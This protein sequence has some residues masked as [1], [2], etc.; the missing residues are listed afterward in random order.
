MADIVRGSGAIIGH[1]LSVLGTPCVTTCRI[2]LLQMNQL[3][4]VCG[5]PAAGFHFGAFT[6][7]GCKVSIF[8]PPFC[9]G[10]SSVSFIHRRRNRKKKGEKKEGGRGRREEGTSRAIITRFSR[11][12]TLARLKLRKSRRIAPR[13][14]NERYRRGQR[15]VFCES[16]FSYVAF[17]VTPRCRDTPPLLKIRLAGNLPLSERSPHA[18]RNSSGTA[19]L[20]Q[21]LMTARERS[22]MPTS[23]FTFRSSQAPDN[24]VSSFS[25][26]E[27]AKLYR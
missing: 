25:A 1:I 22:P 3:C 21:A 20:F 12:A 27:T 17:Y 4:R 10:Y 9:H 6:C 26:R 14:D 8:A 11:R 15:R 18:R 7:E 16:G 19:L 23:N 13:S 2:F 5:E 24:R